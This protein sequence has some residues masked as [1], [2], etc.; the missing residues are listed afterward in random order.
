MDSILALAGK[1]K[2]KVVALIVFALGYLSMQWA[3]VDLQ[4]AI[5]G[6]KDAAVVAPK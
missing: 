2:K 1:N 4:D 3:G 6:D 5:C